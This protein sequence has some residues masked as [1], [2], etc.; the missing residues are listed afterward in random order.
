[1]TSRKHEGFR[2]TKRTVVLDF[3]AESEYYGLEATV[4]AS[5]P[6]ETLFWFQRINENSDTI[7]ALKKFGDDFLMEWNALDDNGKPYPATGD[8]VLSVPDFNLVNT[9]MQGWIEAVTNPPTKSS[10]KSGDSVMSGEQLTEELA[11]SSV[12]LGS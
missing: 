4:L 11:T 7:E 2:V 3:D 9:L 10:D 5:V 1:M 6:F 8:G 12:S